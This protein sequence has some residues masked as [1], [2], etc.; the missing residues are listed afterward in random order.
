MTDA[1]DFVDSIDKGWAATPRL[2]VTER[3]LARRRFGARELARGTLGFPDGSLLAFERM[4]TIRTPR[5]GRRGF[6][7]TEIP[8]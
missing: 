8:S 1:D 2:T 4:P 5:N 6:G 7:L 3:K